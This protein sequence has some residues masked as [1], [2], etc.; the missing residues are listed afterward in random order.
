MP[1]RRALPALHRWP[2]LVGFLLLAPLAAGQGT[3][4]D[5]IAAIQEKVK[6]WNDLT[7]QM[8][9]KHFE[10]Q[11]EVS[12]FYNSEHNKLKVMQRHQASE[13]TQATR[14]LNEPS[15]AYSGG[16]TSIIPVSSGRQAGQTFE[17]SFSALS[18]PIFASAHFLAEKSHWY[19]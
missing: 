3:V 18:K 14:K 1:G 8:Q 17:G 5:T 2:A 15:A 16:P 13:N 12:D 9:K 19:S 6:E 10:L 4:Q 7:A 11:T